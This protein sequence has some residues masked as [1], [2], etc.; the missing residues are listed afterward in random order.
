MKPAAPFQVLVLGTGSHA[1]KS[2]LAAGFCRILSDRGFSVAPFKAQN[3]ALNSAVTDEGLEMGRAQWL[4]ALAARVRPQVRM[5]P[6]LLK[7]QRGKGSQ[8]VLMGRA[9]GLFSTQAY[10]KRWPTV[11]RQAQQ[12]WASLAAEHQA[13]VLEGAGSPAEVNLAHRDLANLETARFSGAPFVLVADIERGGSF[14]ALTGTLAL[15]PAWLRRRCLGVIFNKFRGDARLMDPGLAWLRRRGIKPLGVVP[16]MDGLE[17]EEEDSLG[18]PASPARPAHGGLKAQALRLGH[19]SN[20]NDLMPLQEEAGVQL[21]WVAPGAERARPHLLVIP[22]SK[23]SLADLAA[24]RA[25]GEA[26]RILRW[27]GQGTWILGLCGGFQVLGQGLSDPLGVD[28]G[29][30]GAKALGLGLLDLE[31]RMGRDKVL[32]LRRFTARTRLGRLELSGYEIHHGRSRCGPAAVVE[33]RGPGQEPLLVSD[34]AGVWGSY[35][36]GLLD[37]AP[38]R[39]A[40]LGALAKAQGRRWVG[41]GLDR[42]ER[43]E[44]SLDRWAAH[45]ARHLDLGFLPRRPS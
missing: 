31:T 37:E 3:M 22:G 42:A 10:F 24:L 11:A 41:G 1:G 19:L 8:L 43:R 7:P 34:G 45:L 36:H 23:D 39:R 40:F 33:A 44:R 28:G 4:Q 29:K 38:F 32:A 6:V 2:L 35:L 12:A 27:A 16:W 20:F 9:Q 25:S 13:L 26:E 14:A 17:L 5:N 30:R 18:L 21:S 15:L